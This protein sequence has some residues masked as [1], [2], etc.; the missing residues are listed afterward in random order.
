MKFATSFKVFENC[1]SACNWQQFVASTST[2][3]KSMREKKLLYN[4][5][6]KINLKFELEPRLQFTLLFF[7]LLLTL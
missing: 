7:L 1:F 2:F 4:G 5:D 3:E 6:Y